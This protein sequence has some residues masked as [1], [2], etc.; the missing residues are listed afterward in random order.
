M[1]RNE[2][3]ACMIL[4]SLFPTGRCP[5]PINIIAASQHVRLRMVFPGPLPFSRQ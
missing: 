3:T 5:D 2:K 4:A 1:R